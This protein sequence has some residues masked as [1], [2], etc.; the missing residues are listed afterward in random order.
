MKLTEKTWFPILYMFGATLVLSAVLILFGFFTRERVKN[1]EQL[2]FERAVL[3]ALDINVKGIASTAIHERYVGSVKLIDPSRPEVFARYKDDQLVAY[4]LA[5]SGP[6]FWAPIKGVIGITPDFQSVVGIS[7][8]EQNETPGL[9]G[10]IVKPVFRDQFKDKKITRTGVP[11][12]FRMSTS[13]L[14]E[15]SVH[16]ITG[17]TQTSTRLGKF[18]NEQLA[19]WRDKMKSGD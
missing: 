14:D 19:A 15:N 13:E 18:L 16:M 17:A 5:I 10:E 2:A 11:I 7:F 3:E 12:E 4:A 8:Y 6:G 1:N 9:G